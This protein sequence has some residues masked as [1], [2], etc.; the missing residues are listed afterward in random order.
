[1]LRALRMT[2]STELFSLNASTNSCVAAEESA[3]ASGS[4]LSR[5]KG[6]AARRLLGPACAGGLRAG[7]AR[8]ERVPLYPRVFEVSLEER[9]ALG[10]PEGHHAEA[11]EA[12]ARAL[13]A[14]RLQVGPED[15]ELE[16]LDG[17]GPAGAPD[18]D[19]SGGVGGWRR[20]QAAGG[21]G[22][23]NASRVIV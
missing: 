12:E 23:I 4:A 21:R 3:R 6:A 18:P 14:E 8:H 17:L 11:V 16:R 19:L 2:R 20:G 15:D 13:E 1:M 22:E 9:L 7:G 5:D 10:E